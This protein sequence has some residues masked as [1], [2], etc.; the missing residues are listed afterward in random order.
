MNMLE[1]KIIFACQ[2]AKT[3]SRLYLSFKYYF[4][5]YS[6]NYIA[7][8]CKRLA[9]QGL[10]IRRKMGKRVYYIS[11]K[12]AILQAVSYLN[13]LTEEHAEMKHSGVVVVKSLSYWL[14]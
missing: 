6:Y 4:G 2:K 11:T 8:T 3:P 9:Q 10:L 12:E 14:K 1:A 5:R 7:S 13:M